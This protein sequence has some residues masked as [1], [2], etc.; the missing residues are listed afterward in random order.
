MENTPHYKKN[1]PGRDN[2]DYN[3]EDNSSESDPNMVMKHSFY[4]YVFLS[5]G[6][7]KS[8][9]VKLQILSIFFSRFSSVSLK[10]TGME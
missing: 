10:L 6:H 9:P 3:N 4:N 5:D 2:L 1:D 7:F 8:S